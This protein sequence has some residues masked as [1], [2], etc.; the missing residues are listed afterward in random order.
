LPLIIDSIYI[1]MKFFFNY[2]NL[3]CYQTQIRS[4]QAVEKYGGFDKIFCFGNADIEKNW[5]FRNRTILDNPRG[6]GLWIWKYHFALRLL[7]D[8]QIPE[9]SYICYADCDLY[10][11]NPIDEAIQCLEKY[12]DSIMICRSP[13]WHKLSLI[14]KR[15]ALQL[16]DADKEPYLSSASRAGGF[17]LFKKCPLTRDFFKTASNYSVDPRIIDPFLPNQLGK[18]NYEPFLRH[19]EDEGLTSIVAMKFNLYPYRCVWFN[20]ET[21]KLLVADEAAGRTNGLSVTAPNTHWYTSQQY[22]VLQQG[23]SAYS[24]FIKLTSDTD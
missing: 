19:T 3:Q 4:R 8:P 10:F 13:H 24:S 6:A 18:P 1:V 22:P 2:A 11:T 15:D 16:C 23:R 14:Y 12:G 17:Y 7:D 21:E 9:N 20:K 5:Y